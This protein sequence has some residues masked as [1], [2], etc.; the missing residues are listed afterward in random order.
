MS[1]RIF[2]VEPGSIAA[3]ARLERGDRIETINGNPITDILDYDFYAAD[4]TLCLEV[5]KR[6]GKH[7]TLHIRKEEYEDLGLQFE[8]YLIDQQRSCRNNC[9][10][11]FVDQMPPGMRE[12][13]YFKDDDDRLS[14]LFGNYITLTNMKDEEIDR[15]IKMHISPINV[16][17]HTTNPELRCQMMKNRF[18]GKSLSY[19]HKLANAGIHINCQ[20]VLC[21]GINDGEE[22]TR[23][24]N[25]LAALWPSVQSIACVPVG[26]TRFRDG[27]PSLTA[28]TPQTARET[29]REIERFSSAF[30]KEHGT[31][32]AYPADEFFIQ[33]GL[34][35]PNDAYYEEYSQLENGVGMISLL[36]QEFRLALAQF[37]P[38]LTSR[39][40][41]LATGTAAY[42]FLRG[43]V[44]ELQKKWHTL[45][46][47]VVAIQN[48]YFGHSI[49]VAGLITGTDLAAQLAGRDLGEELLLPA[50]M[51]RHEQDRFLDDM[52]LEELQRRLHIP[53]TLCE[54]DGA[55]LLYA[56]CGV[57][58]C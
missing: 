57:S 34:P 54:N 46:C 18:A 17:V 12:S 56:I 22:L 55:A 53:I 37:D 47:E 5:E 35:F 9:I 11:C 58:D 21:P 30:L 52:T 41:T 42:P 6:S 25:D 3:R 8:T 31:R 38:P 32:L 27:L 2:Q 16:S 28:Y 13:L 1:V 26:L 33:A 29:I 44:D 40:V 14:F 4:E 23:S 10:F 45:P 39:R 50:C 49:T 19:L 20:L 36:Q 43:L 48:D 24:L 7:K 51:L 15:I